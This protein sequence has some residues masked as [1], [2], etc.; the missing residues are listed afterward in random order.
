MLLVK[1]FQLGPKDERF[2]VKQLEDGVFS[3]NDKVLDF[4]FMNG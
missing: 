3:Y 1:R 4:T 2:N